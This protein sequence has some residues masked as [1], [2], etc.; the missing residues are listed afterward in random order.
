MQKEDL[1]GHKTKNTKSHQKPPEAWIP[2]F[3]P[4]DFGGIVTQPTLWFWICGLQK[5]DRINFCCFKSIAIY[6]LEFKFSLTRKHLMTWPPRCLSTLSSRQDRACVSLL[7][8]FASHPP[9]DLG[10][11][12]RG[13]T[14]AHPAWMRPAAV[15]PAASPRPRNRS[16]SSATGLLDYSA[17]PSPHIGFEAF[18]NFQAVWSCP[19]C[20]QTAFDVFI[21]P[22]GYSMCH[23]FLESRATH[24][25]LPQ[26]S[27]VLDGRDSPL[28]R[29]LP[30][31]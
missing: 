11:Q 19:V 21:V 30:G 26:R 6:M 18:L 15:A 25:S 17:V 16:P 2:G 31:A 24:T 10:L 9:P 5:Y 29:D 14:C 22:S 27:Q 4:R 1:R 12:M 8:C 7:S 28:W 3:S 23:V 20:S 13:C